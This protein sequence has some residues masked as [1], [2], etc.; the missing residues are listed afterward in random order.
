LSKFNLF[1]KN[2]ILYWFYKIQKTYKNKSPNTHFAEFGEDIIVSRIFKNF[3]SGTYVDIGAYHPFKG[4][5]TYKL[6]K[7]GWNGVNIDISEG[8][9]DLFNIARPRDKNINCAISNFTGE[10]VYFE[11][12]PINQQNSLIK[13]DENQKQKKIKCYKLSDL[14]NTQNIFK[15]D[16]MN[17]D[18]EGN[19]LDILKGINFQNINP[20]LFTIE[21]NSF[22]SNE[23]TKKNK[24]NLMNNNNYELIN[25]VGVTMFFIKKDMINK[26]HDLI[27]I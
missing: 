9:I 1:K 21:D 18:T 4:S 23:Q 27:R 8:S 15:V 20:L 26:I 11:N 17:I 7:K 14:L 16:Y 5:L 10:T 22:N 25:I 13:C 12:S 3:S 19:E 24:I 6:Y 2:K